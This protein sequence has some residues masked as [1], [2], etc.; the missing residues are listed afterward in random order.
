M[1]E[2]LLFWLA[3][4]WVPVDGHGFMVD[5]FYAS[6]WLPYYALPVPEVTP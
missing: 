2:Q 3:V 1:S 5:C 4:I 6:H